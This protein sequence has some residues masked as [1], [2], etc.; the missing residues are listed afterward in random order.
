MVMIFILGVSDEID[1]DLNIH[2]DDMNGLCSLVYQSLH[3]IHI[4]TKSTTSMLHDSYKMRVDEMREIDKNTKYDI[5]NNMSD[6]ERLLYINLEEIGFSPD[7]N[8][9]KDV[10]AN[11]TNIMFDNY[12]Y[13]DNNNDP[14]EYIPYAG[15]NPDDD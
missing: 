11:D 8:E 5:K 15:E 2:E 12:K 9:F 6:D 1:N 3:E 14:V 7:I 4:V 13:E 10:Y